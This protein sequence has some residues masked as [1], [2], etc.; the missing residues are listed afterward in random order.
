MNTKIPILQCPSVTEPDRLDGV[1]EISPWTAAEVGVLTDYSPTIFVDKRRRQDPTN[2]TSATN[3][4][5]EASP[6]GSAMP[7]AAGSPGLGIAG[8]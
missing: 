1:P 2:P 3:L 8:L 7:P 4:V 6:F 5:D